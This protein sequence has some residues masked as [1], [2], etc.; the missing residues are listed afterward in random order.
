MDASSTDYRFEV[1]LS[2]AGDDK[3]EHVRA[4]AE[5]LQDRLG[6]GRVFFDEWFIAEIAGFDGNL[7]LPN[8][9]QG[10]S[11][12]VVVCVCGRYGEKPWTQ[13]EWRGILDWERD[14]RDADSENLKRLRLLFLRF[15]DGD[16]PGI[17]RTALVPDVRDWPPVKI[18]ELILERLRLVKGGARAG[19][20]SV[21]EPTPSP[22]RPAGES[23]P[24]AP[25]F[26]ELVD[27]IARRGSSG[28][29][30]FLGV[31]VD[32]P[33]GGRDVEREELDQ[34][35][36]ADAP[37]LGLLVATAGR[38]KSALLVNWARRVA[39][40]GRA[41]V[42]FM[43]VSLRFDT[44]RVNEVAR[45]IAGRLRHLDASRHHAVPPNDPFEA[46]L[47]CKETFRMRWPGARPLL[48]VLDG[49]DEAIGWTCEKLLPPV[50]GDNVKLLVAARETSTDTDNWRARLR[51]RD[52][53]QFALRRLTPSTVAEIVRSVPE[54]RVVA[55][56]DSLMA[57]FHALTDGD[58]LIVQL[59]LDLL[60]QRR[61]GSPTERMTRLVRES[62]SA[63]EPLRTFF[64]GWWKDQEKQWGSRSGAERARLEEVFNLLACAEGPLGLADLREL[65]G[66]PS[67]TLH[68]RLGQIGRLVIV[69]RTA[70]RYVFSHSRL[71][72]Y[73]FDRLRK[74]DA[75]E[76]W[77]RR[78]VAYGDA[79]F[80]RLEED[81]ATLDREAFERRYGYVL[82]HHALH[83]EKSAPA[84]L[85]R[86]V[87]RPWLMGWRALD[88]DDGVHGGFYED[89]RRA[90]DHAT[91]GTGE[92]VRALLVKSS[93]ASLSSNLPWSLMRR[94][95]E[96]KLWSLP[97]ALRWIE[98]VV[99]DE[100]QASAL[101]VLA[102][103]LDEAEQHKVLQHAMALPSGYRSRALAR[104][105]SKLTPPLQEVAL[106]ALLADGRILQRYSLINLEDVVEGLPPEA[107]SKLCNT[108]R[109]LPGAAQRA[110]LFF[111]VVKS[112][113][114]LSREER[115]D[116]LAECAASVAEITE[117]VE[118]AY[119]RCEMAAIA[120]GCAPEMRGQLLQEAWDDVS[121]ASRGTPRDTVHGVLQ[122]LLGQ[123][124]AMVP[125]AQQEILEAAWRA[126]EGS[127]LG[128]QALLQLGPGLAR[129]GLLSRVLERCDAIIPNE[130]LRGSLLGSLL[131]HSREHTDQILDRLW[132]LK[133]RYHA[134]EP[135]TYKLHL[136]T[137][138]QR[139]QCHAEV[140]ELVRRRP[141][142][143]YLL[144]RI[145]HGMDASHPD[146]PRLLAAARGLSPTRRAERLAACVHLV[147]DKERG[148]L[149]EGILRDAEEITISE[150]RRRLLARLVPVIQH[151][152]QALQSFL[153]ASRRI[154]DE[155]FLADA[156]DQVATVLAAKRHATDAAI[157]ARR[158]T[159]TFTRNP[160]WG[161]ETHLCIL[162]SLE[163]SDARDNLWESASRAAHTLPPGVR[164]AVLL[165]SLAQT[166]P[167]RHQQRHLAAVHEAIEA[168]ADPFEK[169][170]ARIQLLDGLAPDARRDT[171]ALVV[172]D[173]AA[174]MSRYESFRLIWVLFTRSSHSERAP[175]QDVLDAI[176]MELLRPA[177]PPD[178]SRDTEEERP[179]LD[180][181]AYI[182]KL[183]PFLDVDQTRAALAEPSLSLA[184]NLEA[185]AVRLAELTQHAEALE[186]VR[187]L[188]RPEDRARG[189]SRLLDHLPRTDRAAIIAEA[190][191][192]LE[193]GDR[194]ESAEALS[195]LLPHLPASEQAACV[196]AA[197]ERA[198]SMHHNKRRRETLRRLADGAA[199]YLSPDDLGAAW[200][201]LLARI[202]KQR[203][204]ELVTDLVA[205]A[206]LMLHV[207]GADSLRILGETLLEI[208]DWFP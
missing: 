168:L 25:L 208:G 126:I 118:R 86:L 127:E 148:S 139:A 144:D 107:L 4:V 133:D 73:F 30:D 78:L 90:A 8:L 35:L 71:R 175:H 187:R 202:E 10:H 194:R 20:Q 46:L 64:H 120:A 61:E 201:G 189:L 47:E 134:L 58:P 27:G 74:A 184:I 174:R 108:A 85:V 53:S 91:T 200:A 177:R 101:V 102:N 186:Q 123:L 65:T 59:Q 181:E 172:N 156:V 26:P 147:P 15:G 180:N 16:V 37:R 150:L 82:R 55:D 50:A 99:D 167:E 88:G 95:V 75:H 3:R 70:D 69:D 56:D 33:F 157:I 129:N 138:T 141:T 176:V 19:D 66:D 188:E 151:D 103:G 197:L 163:A 117:S 31:Y 116:L 83:L 125:A 42:V 87:S 6:K 149:V 79:R 143:S 98:R 192:E 159:D 111:A 206:P 198:C 121:A 109:S 11:R 182:E 130:Y 29:R 92:H 63:D 13:E 106:D 54:F 12:L 2:F 39:L 124:E 128:W 28:I 205:V 76:P 161:I 178:D 34:W 51:W 183:A 173:L 119:K 122:F 142:H 24:G 207:D 164:R 145:A 185:L 96:T 32:A 94:L 67:E 112:A 81:A 52:C 1:A 84:E 44:A 135:L 160:H 131:P 18:A 93:I 77:Q 43:P 191:R 5:I 23:Q 72:D 62:S 48:V 152:V 68:D 137:P 166:A 110:H 132:R 100:E 190:Q 170:Y 114:A 7:L 104:M 105:I 115:R 165:A 38:G 199:R 195:F 36:G 154:G 171:I 158:S 22:P 14:L 169:T 153:E 60:S 21:G 113:Q 179:H 196:R 97:R 80:A 17:P 204:E 57:Q 162:R 140:L 203:R 9:Y 193:A 45:A 155:A 49:L 40:D 146:A 136:L 41:D 89:V